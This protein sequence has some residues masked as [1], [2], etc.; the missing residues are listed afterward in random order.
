MQAVSHTRPD[1]ATWWLAGWLLIRCLLPAQAEV[2]RGQAEIEFQATSTLHNFSGTA[3]TNP[4]ACRVDRD[5]TVTVLACTAHVAV[6]GMDTRHTK[7][8]INMR[9]MFA[10]DRHPAVIGVMDPIRVD[11]D[12][13]SLPVPIHLTIREQTFTVPATLSDW[14]QTGT[15]LRFDLSLTLSLRL[16]GLVPPVI[17]GFIRVGDAVQVR[18]RVKLESPLDASL[19]D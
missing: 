7:R 9:R 4:F 8:D 12:D 16:S 3:Q 11:P 13:L 19:Q 2:W 17:L 5:G 6:A 1:H 14:Q 15:D 10:A 18:I